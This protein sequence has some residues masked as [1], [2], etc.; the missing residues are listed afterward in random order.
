MKHKISEIFG[1][2][3]EDFYLTRPCFFSR[4]NE[5]PAKTLNDE[6]WHRHIDKD[7]YGKFI[8]T[9]LI[10]LSDHGSDFEG[11]DFKFVGGL[12]HNQTVSPKKGL[13]STFSSGSENPHLVEKVTSG[14]RYALTIAFACDPSGAI[15]PPKFAGR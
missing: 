11:G 1:L 15:E 2:S 6:Y 8:Y 9:A 12:A 4:L 7:T 13:F 14:E 3:V 10:Y 5:K